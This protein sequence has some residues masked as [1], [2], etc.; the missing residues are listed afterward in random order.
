METNPQEPFLDLNVDYDAGNLLKDTSRWTKFIAVV[1]II[2]VAMML[3][4]L[5]LGGSYLV[6]LYSRI[7]PGIEAYTGLVVFV[8]VLFMIV[9]GTMVFLL[10]QF[11]NLVRRGIEI[12]DQEL[13]NKGLYSL[14]IYFIMSGLFAIL[15]LIG[16]LV[17]LTK[18]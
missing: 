18:I 16:N 2:G 14:R 12:Q 6:G 1:G 13:F 5:L 9:L 15:A 11:S 8:M 17:N 7:L 4:V 10:Y 3:L